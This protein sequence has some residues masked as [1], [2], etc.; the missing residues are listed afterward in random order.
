MLRPR[1]G[2]R[3]SGPSGH[4]APV[5]WLHPVA[6]TRLRPRKEQGKGARGCGD[7]LHAPIGTLEAKAGQPRQD[8][9]QNPKSRTVTGQ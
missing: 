8:A 3:V 5:S 9:T 2:L 1:P 6:V 7:G 4:S